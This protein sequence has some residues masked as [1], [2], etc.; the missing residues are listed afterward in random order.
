MDTEENVHELISSS[1]F[2]LVSKD[3][4]LNFECMNFKIKIE[5]YIKTER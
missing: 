1:S 5:K 4:I 2:I 3:D